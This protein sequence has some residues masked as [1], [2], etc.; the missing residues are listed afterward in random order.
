MRWVYLTIIILFAVA[1]VVFA[2]QNFET[3]TVSFLKVNL[4]LPLALLSVVV[5]LLGA[6]TGG[7]LFAL[8][9][10]SYKGSWRGAE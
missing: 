7:S 9:R 4:S 6:A 2:A 3:V 5:Y 8:L 1:I 10:R